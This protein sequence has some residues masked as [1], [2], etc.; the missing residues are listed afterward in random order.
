MKTAKHFI[1]IL[2]LFLC[3]IRNSA[4]KPFFY[5]NATVYGEKEGYVIYNRAHNITEDNKGLIWIGSENGLQSFD[6]TYFK[7][8]KHSTKDT[9]S[10][11]GNYVQF[12]Y[13]D[14]EDIYWAYIRGKGLY[15]YDPRMERFS[16]YHYQNEKEFNLHPFQQFQVGLPFEDS[17][18]RL[19]VPLLGYGLAEINKKRNIVIPYKI[20]IPGNCGSFYDASWVT[21]IFEDNKGAFWLATNGGIVFFN[22]ETGISEHITEPELQSRVIR[23]ERTS[24]F[25]HF[26]PFFNNDI[27]IGTWG[28][29]IKK[30]NTTT[31]RFETFL[32]HPKT[33]DGTKNVCSGIWQKDSTHLWVS[34]LDNGLLVFD[35]QTQQFQPVR[36]SGNENFIFTGYEMIQAKDGSLWMT[37][38]NGSLVKISRKQFFSSYTF[39]NDRA[40]I[41]AKLKA[42]T[43]LKMGNELFIGAGFDTRI[44]SYDLN[45]QTYHSYEVPG[46]HTRGETNFLIAAPEQKGFFAGGYYGLAFFNVIK[47]KFEPFKTDSSA[48]R[49]L[50]QDLV[51]ATKGND[52]TIWI[53]CRNMNALLRYFPQTGEI[54]EYPLTAETKSDQ[55]TYT[56]YWVNS[57]AVDQDEYVWFS[58]SHFGLGSIHIPS[59]KIVFF[60][61]FRKKDFPTGYSTDVCI[62]DDRNVFFTIISEGVWKLN[63]PF[64]TNENMINYNRTNGLPSDM[65]NFIHQDQKKKIWLFSSNGLSLFDPEM[66]TSK[67]FSEID[68]LKN[69]NLSTRPYEDENGSVYIGF[70]NS[71][72][73]FR[74]DSLV[75]EKMKI[76]KLV[77]HDFKVNN[78]S[79]PIN[80]NYITNMNLKPDQNYIQFQYAAIT[81]DN[82]QQLNYEYKLEG[83]DKT[84]IHT[85]NIAMGSYNNLPPGDY[86]LKIRVNNSTP[87]DS[88]NYFELPIVIT[89]YWYK[90]IWFKSL[91][92]IIIL[93][94]V[95]LAYRYRIGIMHKEAKLKAEFDQK[96]AEVEMRALRAQM[97]PHFI[98]NSLSSINRYIVK[99]DNKTASNYLTKFSKLIR[100]ILDNSEADLISVEKEIQSLQLYIEMEALRFD[101]VFTYTI[102]VDEKIDQEENFIP[103][104]LLQPYVENAIWHGLLHKESGRGKLSINLSKI[105]KTMLA[106]EITDNGIG[107]QKAMEM[108]SKEISNK[109]SYGMQISRDRLA[110]LNYSNGEPASVVV[111]DLVDENGIAQGTRVLLQIPM[112]NKVD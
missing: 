13:Q 59:G 15:N 101:H 108:K 14:S 88:T 29:G 50:N 4:Q 95:Y 74:P 75:K 34:T 82:P 32:W 10:L 107:R 91:L 67:S 104:M 47:Q 11:P 53:G 103:S 110:L 109:K 24:V 71:F 92:G 5:I 79:W 9:N 40:L 99:S 49:L 80:V 31:K 69:K 36:Q 86:T 97:N 1:L 48:E 61:S 28:S 94:L 66:A 25:N 33:W 55:A 56:D 39:N 64:T 44:Y 51:C 46:K 7:T 52:N 19:W 89:G 100:L 98:F 38:T 42:N 27:W 20:C 8:Y 58:H 111:E 43:F 65:I 102:D 78:T 90:S 106:A 105:S 63:Q 76:S 60:N 12:I 96:M 68:G 112:Q 17:K 54:K 30:L 83:F 41:P 84:W 81:H 73:S 85:G 77:I 2:I 21:R 93:I 72:Q 23:N 70:T 57:I 62:T 22:P 16:K 45:R 37:H 3:I 18:H 35:L 87:Q 6:G 26:G